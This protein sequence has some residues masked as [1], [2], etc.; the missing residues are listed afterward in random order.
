MLA[1]ETSVDLVL[2]G[3]GV[4]SL[5]LA[6]AVAELARAGYSFVRTA[7]TSGGSIVGAMVAALEAS[8]ADVAGSI[9][10][11]ARDI[12][13]E[14]FTAPPSHRLFKPFIE[15]SSLVRKAGLHDGVALRDWLSATLADLGVRTFGDLRLPDEHRVGEPARQ[16][17]RLVVTASDISIAAP[18]TWP[19]DCPKYGIAADRLRVADAIRMSTAVPFF[20]TPV[21]FRSAQG[22][23]HTIVDGGIFSNCPVTIFDPVG[24]GRPHR[25]VI[26]V[27][28]HGLMPHDDRHVR[29]VSG[30]LSLGH[31]IAN[32]MMSAC[33]ATI[34]DDPRHMERTISIPATRY[35]TN[36]LN[37]HL[38]G[39]Q[40]EKLIDVGRAAAAEFLATWDFGRYCERYHPVIF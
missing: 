9:I 24:G 29:R 39:R 20:F 7:G 11:I 12:P 16:E 31:C 33:D 32:S 1:A 14:T 19:W 34:L 2:A 4:L 27:N 21:R 28:L 38:S 35:R 37:F 25:P 23:V 30:P 15:V 18:V 13:F 8:G 40:K 10:D 5:A 26:A 6:G 3:G 36:A 22:Q 17:C